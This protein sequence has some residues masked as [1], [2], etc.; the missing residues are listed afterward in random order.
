MAA[1]ELGMMELEGN[2]QHGSEPTPFVSAPYEEG[3][4]EDAAILID[5]AVKFRAHYGRCPD[6]HGLI[7]IDIPASGSRL[8]RKLVIIT[9]ELLQVVAVGNIAV[10]DAALHVIDNHI[11]AQPVI[12][13][14]LA[15]LGQQ[16]EFWN[17]TG[18]L[19]YAPA[20]E[21]VELQPLPPA[22]PSK[23]RDVKGLD[24]RHHRHRRLHPQFE[25]L[26]ATGLFGVDF[27]FHLNTMSGLFLR[28]EHE[29]AMEYVGPFLFFFLLL[30]NNNITPTSLIQ[31][32]TK[33]YHHA[34]FRRSLRFPPLGNQQSDAHSRRQHRIHLLLS[35]YI[36]A[37]FPTADK[38]TA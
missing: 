18:G 7:V 33:P 13:E 10:A 16:V 2:R 35:A 25:S 15:V 34:A 36:D 38:G 27:L 9:S 20:Q 12:F 6:N 11:D 31:V 22:G 14:Q 21:H 19:A 17:L 32:K 1:I 37:S 28:F 30:Q 29:A 26:C 4:V 8:L 23:A 24:E 5:D 3:V